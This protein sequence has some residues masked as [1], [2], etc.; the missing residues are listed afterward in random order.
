MKQ[1]TISAIVALIIL[2]PIIIMGGNVFNIG[3]YIISLL[4]LK[5]FMDIKETKK[6]IPLFVKIIS[7]VF[8]TVMILYSFGGDLFTLSMDYRLIGALFL[9]FLTPTVLYHDKSKYSINDA[10]YLMGGIFFLAITMILLIN[11]RGYRL[12]ALIYLVL[13]TTMTDT[14]AYI[15]GMLIGKHKL[16]ED[17]S[18]KKTWEGTI[19]GS[20]MGTFVS[21]V[22]YVTVINPNVNL[23]IIILVS[24]FLSIIGQFGDLVFS[25][26]KRYYGKKDFSN[27]MPG[28]GGVLDRLDSLI[29]V[30]LGFTFFITII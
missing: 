17:I 12:A 18:P 25:A 30:L 24:L 9:A 27:I 11:V 23:G 16:L 2:L 26:I 7:V 8:Y 19:G 4:A 5:E 22:F 15:T 28:H 3:V 10:F 20:L 21:T 1:R 29:F 6:Q 14:F 13:I